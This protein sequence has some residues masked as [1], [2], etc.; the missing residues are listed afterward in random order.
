MARNPSGA[1][2]ELATVVQTEIRQSRRYNRQ[3]GEK[4]NEKPI[5]YLLGDM[6]QYIPHEDGRSGVVSL[7]VADTVGWMMPDLMRLFFAGDRIVDYQ[8]TGPEDEEYTEQSSDFINHVFVNEC[9]GYNVVWD[10]AHDGLVLRNGVIKYWWDEQPEHQTRSFSGLDEEAFAQVVL[11]DDV[12]VLEHDTSSQSVLGPDGQ[13]LEV[14]THDVKVR[15]LTRNGRIKVESVPPEEFLIDTRA[16]K[17]DDA[18]FVAHRYEATRSELIKDGYDRDVVEDLPTGTTLESDEEHLARDEEYETSVYSPRHDTAMEVVEV[19][20]CYILYDYNNDGVAE[21]CKVVMA[22]GSDGRNIL[23]WEEWGDPLPFVDLNPERVPHRFEGRSIA[24]QTMDVQNVKTVLLR[25][26][27]DNLY[28]SINPERVAIEGQVI[29]PDSLQNP[30]F[31]EVHRV[32]SDINAIK[33]LQKPFVASEAFGMLDYWDNVVQRRTGVSQHSKAMEPERLQNQNA[34][35]AVLTQSQAHAK[36]ELVGRNYSNGGL[37]RLF[38][39][40]LQLMV[41]HQDREMVVKLRNKWVTVNPSLWNPNMDAVVN[42]GL[43]TGSR[44]RD[45]GMLQMI[46]EIQKEVVAN[47]GPDNPIVKPSQLHN[48]VEKIIHSAG[49]QTADMF[50][51]EV[52][53]EEMRQWYMQKQAEQQ[54]QSQV[55]DPQTQAFVQVE[56]AKAEATLKKAQL[57]SEIAKFKAN[58]DQELQKMKMEASAV[59]VGAK[60]DFDREMKDREEAFEREKAAFEAQIKELETRANVEVAEAKLKLDAKKE[61]VTLEDPMAGLSSVLLGMSS[62][63]RQM[64]SQARAPRRIDRDDDGGIRGVV[65]DAEPVEETEPETASLEDVV[66]DLAVSVQQ[67]QA[68]MAA[69][70]E[71]IRDDMNRVVGVRPMLN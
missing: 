10:A 2:Q 6:D 61:G 43:G 46:L 29:D 31:G 47:L 5:K 28:D 17:I 62:A 66:A 64:Q 15:K 12:E 41:N 11:N 33:D 38:K 22:G 36:V 18:R 24:D 26:T 21:W 55:P 67:M 68:A 50:F 45:L 1:E 40:M 3:T 71:V 23:D 57:D 30:R 63:I 14:E 9:D 4:D 35:S 69:P 44:E 27:L 8:P 48:T 65:I 20:E 60:N 54:A 58:G 34:T 13:E 19:F 56:M 7:D 16:K 51:T 49:M 37:K 70:K 25:N 59:E 42:T 52:S 39:G 53:D 32:K